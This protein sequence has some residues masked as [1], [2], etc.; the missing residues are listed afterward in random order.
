MSNRTRAM[1]STDPPH[2]TA[3]LAGVVTFAGGVEAGRLRGTLREA[4]GAGVGETAV[5][6]P[7]AV[8]HKQGAVHQRDGLLC[9]FHGR[10]AN[11][12]TVAGSLGL[13][14]ETPPTRIVTAAYHR[15][16][17]GAVER[18]RGEFVIA[19]WDSKQ[20]QAWLACD[21]LGA[22]SFFLHTTAGRLTFATDIGEIL[23]LLPT[24]PDLDD[25]SAL[26]WLA[27]GAV[28]PNRTLYAGVHRLPAGSLLKFDRVGCSQRSY[29]RPCYRPPLR[30]APEDA[31]F[32]V[33][34]GLRA[35]IAERLR[36]HD[37]AGI[38][39]SGGLDSGMVAAAA[40]EAA[41]ALNLVGYSMTFPDLPSVDES[42]LIH[43]VSEHLA[44]PNVQMR[45]RG[46]SML[47][48]GLSF[49]ERWGLP[50]P[51]PNITFITAL[52]DFAA[53]EGM[54]VMLDGEGG[55]ELFGADSFLL[56]HL[57]RRGRLAAAWNICRELPG[58]G[59]H[60]T[61]GATSRAFWA[62]AVLGAAPIPLQRLRRS[63]RSAQDV[64]PSWL[65]DS[66]ARILRED[67]DP[68]D[69]KR[70]RAPLW[71][72]HL[73]HVLT[74][75]REE[76]RMV[77]GLWQIGASSGLVRHHPLLGLELVELVLRLPPEYAFRNRL[78]RAVQREA[79]QSLVPDVII[80]RQEKS[81]FTPVLRN[82]LLRG[83]LH[84]ARN[85]LESPSA[86]TRRFV[87]Q[88]ALGAQIDAIGLP[89]EPMSLPLYTWRLT[90]MECWLRS[91]ADP[92]FPTR[93]LSEMSLEPLRVDFATRAP[94]AA[95]RRRAA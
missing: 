48:G 35:T 5:E 16:G 39:L 17:P 36:G 43:A 77:D 73:S 10:L 70:S 63:V 87:D 27:L 90:M 21:P 41:P 28:A 46:G 93:C 47:A 19:L 33:R 80:R 6:G 56:A 11:Q 88:Q 89:G 37:R 24:R 84:L 12:T 22:R 74:T 49:L 23:R 42:R 25:R 55:D 18:L 62:L 13:A 92:G 53:R 75:R 82:S 61:L 15:W 8:G 86:E 2:A 91:Q 69:W 14:P 52:Q 50:T 30:I 9:A 54:I 51:A 20:A 67:Y 83:E 95:G 65:T 26:Q 68:L 1:S 7:F 72:S 81:F 38:L 45:V 66:A 64:A 60:P 29:W 59:E 94:A 40:R 44:I 85:L 71:W 57:L 4:I 58:L 78:D 76:I 31:A 79:M 34:T 3:G 32:E